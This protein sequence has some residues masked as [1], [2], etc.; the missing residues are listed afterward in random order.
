MLFLH[1]MLNL[2]FNG[3]DPFFKSTFLVATL[4]WAYGFLF[5]LI[6]ALLIFGDKEVRV[7]A[8][9]FLRSK[10]LWYVQNVQWVQSFIFSQW[11]TL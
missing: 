1:K 7:L 4:F 10:I 3:L 5:E 2:G 9:P 6:F 8:E 11:K